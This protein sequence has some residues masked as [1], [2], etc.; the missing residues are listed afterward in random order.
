MKSIRN[1]QFNQPLA[2]NQEEYNTLFINLNTKDPMCPATVCFEFTVDE[3][4]EITKTGKAYYQ[5]CLFLSERYD[6]EGNVIG[7]GPREQFH[8]MNISVH[9]PL[10]P[11]TDVVFEKQSLRDYVM[12][13]GLTQANKDMIMGVIYAYEQNIEMI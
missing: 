12:S 6:Q 8:P 13:T 9:N 3:I 10:D 1:E 2:E 4:E 11:V 7:F 5:Q